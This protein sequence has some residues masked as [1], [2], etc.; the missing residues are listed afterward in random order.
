MTEIP[1]RKMD[2]RNVNKKPRNSASQ[3][4]VLNELSLLPFLWAC[5]RGHR[6]RVVATS[7]VVTFANALFKRIA[8]KSISD[9]AAVDVID[10]L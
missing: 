10:E 1:Q 4:V 7:P 8:A 9:G 2:C 6:P 5:W 3:L